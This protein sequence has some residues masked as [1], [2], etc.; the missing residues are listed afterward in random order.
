MALFRRRSTPES[1]GTAEDLQVDGMVEDLDGVDATD[2]EADGNAS[3]AAGPAYDRVHGPFDESEA[4]DADQDIPRLD[5]GSL[6]IPGLAGIGVQVEADPAT[7]EVRAVT[8]VGDQAAVQLQAFAAPRSDGL[9]DEIR[10]EMLAELGATAGAQVAEAVGSFGPELRGMLPARTAEGKQVSQPVRFVGI[11]GPRWFLR[12]VFLG[13]AAVEPDP[14]D[15]LHR[16]VRQTIVARGADAMAPRDPL[17]LTLPE[18][19][20]G[21]EPPIEGGAADADEVADEVDEQVGESQAA[22][23]QAPNDRFAGLKPFE[24]GPEITETR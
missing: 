22:E 16:L 14:A 21:F 6:Q 7:Q 17:P 19:P 4:D 2:P 8:G 11:D 5:L 10:A 1:T 23:S 9:W 13:R 15:D 20:A 3:A 18:Q 12:V 24:R